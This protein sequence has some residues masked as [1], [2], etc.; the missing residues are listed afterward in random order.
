MKD[1]PAKEG[2]VPRINTSRSR[3]KSKDMGNLS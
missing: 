2:Q 1:K 3:T